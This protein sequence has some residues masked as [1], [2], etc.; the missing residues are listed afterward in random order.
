[1]LKPEFSNLESI[2]V[3]CPMH[4]DGIFRNV[5]ALVITL[6][7]QLFC[8]II[9]HWFQLTKGQMESLKF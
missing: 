7:N 1:M 6:E 3:L 9:F 5:G 8:W 4:R 2:T